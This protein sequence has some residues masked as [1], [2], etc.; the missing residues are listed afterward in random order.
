[1]SL[2]AWGHQPQPAE[3]A[4][5]KLQGT[6]PG[7]RNC[8]SRG[9]GFRLL[10]LIPFAAERT[11]TTEGAI[12]KWVTRAWTRLTKPQRDHGLRCAACAPWPAWWRT[13]GLSFLGLH[14]LGDGQIS[15][16]VPAQAPQPSGCAA[17]PRAAADGAAVCPAAGSVPVP[18]GTGPLQVAA[19]SS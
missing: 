12:A 18:P 17:T 16:P 15:D 8:G 5:R 9:R 13:G 7:Q 3:S 10:C 6:R 2:E 4:G 11:K 1:M 19:P 14:P